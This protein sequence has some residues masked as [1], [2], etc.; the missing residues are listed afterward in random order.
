MNRLQEMMHEFKTDHRQTPRQYMHIGVFSW[1][2]KDRF[3][4]TVVTP[5]TLS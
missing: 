4:F 2:R 5:I 1:Y 3:H